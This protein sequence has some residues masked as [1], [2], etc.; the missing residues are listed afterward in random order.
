MALILMVLVVFAALT[1]LVA[2]LRIVSGLPSVAYARAVQRLQRTVD[3]LESAY[4]VRRSTLEGHQE[5][6]RWQRLRAAGGTAPDRAGSGGVPRAASGAGGGEPDLDGLH[7][8][9]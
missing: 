8:P 3:E 6:A 5:L 4:Q 2:G 7:P 9:P 1:L